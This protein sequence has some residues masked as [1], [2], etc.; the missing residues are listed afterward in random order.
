MMKTTRFALLALI[1]VPVMAI[2]A[3]EKDEYW[4]T[5]DVLGGLELRGIGP[6]VSSGRVSDIAVDPTDHSRWFVTV[7]SGGVWRTTNSGTTWDPVFDDEGSPPARSPLRSSTSAP[8]DPP[9]PR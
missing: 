7:A 9:G 1:L 8:P 2:A 3:A 4:L 6:G 5:S